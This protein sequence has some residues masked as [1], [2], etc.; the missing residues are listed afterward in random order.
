MDNKLVSIVVPI[1]NIE[2]YLHRCVDSILRQT[3]KNIEI[4]LVDDGSPDY[5]GTICD[6]YAQIDQRIK[7]IHKKNGGLSDARN[8]GIKIATGEYLLFVDSDDWIADNAIESLLNAFEKYTEVDIVAGSSVDVHEANGEL[9]ETKYSV[10]LGTERLL[11]KIEAI[12]DNLL[13]GW[14]AWNKLYR[15]ELFDGVEF[16][17]GVI[18]EDEAILL[19]VI[20]KC[21]YAVQ[22]GVP[23]YYYFLRENSITTSEFS[24]KKMDWYNNCI[25]NC[26]YVQENHSELYPEAQYRLLCCILYLLQFMLLDYNRYEPQIKAITKKV[27]DEHQSMLSNSYITNKQNKKLKLFLFVAKYRLNGIYSAIYRMYRRFR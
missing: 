2:K 14:A 23:T 25:S 6:T 16:P 18:N 9:I 17:V 5:C 20:D 27:N 13:N 10:G 12:K 1:Y 15:R 4:I 19:H 26:A 7:V 8:A 24:E 22:I 11:S 3:Y 21:R